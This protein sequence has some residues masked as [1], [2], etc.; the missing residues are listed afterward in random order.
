MRTASLIV[1]SL[2]L[3]SALPAQDPAGMEE[4]IQS[5]V[6]PGQFMGAVLVARGDTVLLSKGYGSADL[7]WAI[8]N[9]PTT[10]FRIGSVTKQFTAAAILLL[11][12]RG[13]L[14][15]SDFVKKHLPDAPAA[16]DKVTIFHLLTHTSGIPS[17]TSLP[18]YA[19]KQPFAT[20]PDQLVARFRDLPLEFEPGS[21]WNYS[22]SGYVLLGYLIERVSGQSYARFLHENIFAPLSMTNSGYDVTNAILPRRARGYSPGPNGPAP[23]GYVDMTIPFSAG[24]LYSTTEDLLRWE[25]GLFG[26]RLLSASS[27]Q[28]MTTP[29][30]NDYAFG[31]GVG[32]K[33]GRKFIAHGGGIEGFNSYLRYDPEDQLTI[34]VLANLNGPAADALAA[35]LGSMAQGKKVELL[36]T[37]QA[38]TLPVAELRQ[39]VGTYE[40]APG[41][42][43]Q[44]TVEGDQLMTQLTGQPKFPLFAE[45]ETRFFL[46]VVDAQVDF[47]KDAQG[48]VVAF[49][50]HQNGQ[51]VRAPR[52][53]DRVELP[54]ERKAID[55]PVATLQRYV[56]TYELAPGIVFTIALAGNQLTEQLTG[57]SAYP[58]FPES[59]TRF[60]LKVV[61]AQIEF[62]RDPAGAVTSLILHQGGRDQSARRLAK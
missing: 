27:L 5:Y 14:S 21:K 30:K 44:M 47:E 57:Q 50:L 12:E 52:T 49:T 17:F 4:L 8:P 16:W 43:C 35:K 56:G 59:E 2:A 61:D 34:V 10:K 1:A 33:D 26:G 60:F 29:F 54:P 55:V 40:L 51:N 36:K 18:D 25:R 9:D 3:V 31:V 58:I 41:Q 13:K 22:N 6:T 20:T 23:A 42:K 19:A 24:A 7:E 39:F 45:T 46:K 62:V 38:R 32:T 37:R 15:T 53:S 28:K 48:K 11:E